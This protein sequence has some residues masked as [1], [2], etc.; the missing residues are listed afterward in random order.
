MV[1]CPHLR[2]F[3]KQ[4]HGTTA[5]EFAVVAPVLLLLILGII[6]FS[7]IM[8]TYHIMESAT[9]SSA[10]LGATG[11][12]DTGISREDTIRNAITARA[13]NWI[14]PTKLTITSKSYSQFDQIHDPEP[15][16]DTNHNGIHDPGE[17]YTDIN[18]NGQWDAD[19]GTA[20]YGG[21]G[22]VVVY[23]ISYPWTILTPLAGPLIGTNGTF[24]ITTHA[25]VKNE[26]Y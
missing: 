23:A 1:F 8:L 26:P 17:P 5:I 22:D 7:L 20:G 19:M 13:G 24:T 6:E 21:T 18:G 3:I 11:H 10:R 2:P 25:V 14:D 16:T 12:V 9:S 4:Q 15:F